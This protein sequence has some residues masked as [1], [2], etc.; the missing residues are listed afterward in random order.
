MSEY[1]SNVA[2]VIKNAPSQDPAA[3]ITG[4]PPN[5]GR[6]VLPQIST[7][8]GLIS[9]ISRA[10]RASDEALKHALENARFMRNDL[11]IMECVESR[12]RSVALLNWHLEPED[13]KSPLQKK[14]CEDLTSTILRIPRFTQFRDVL[15]HAIWF[16]RYAIQNRYQWRDV[17]GISRCLPTAW[18][19]VNGDKLVFRIDDGS[20]DPDQVGIRVGQTVKLVDPYGQERS[21]EL[22]DRG[23]AYFLEPWERKLLCLHRHMIEDGEF[24]S[25]ENADRINGVGIRSRIYWEWFQ[26]QE[27]LGF[28]MEYL[29]RSAFGIEIWYYPMGNDNA[30]EATR[31]AASERIG[32]GR[33]I[34][35]VGKPLGEDGAAYG[36]DRIE[37][38]LGGVEA[39]KDILDKY[40]GHRI[41]RYILGQTLTSEAD[42]TG[43]GSGL[44]E[45]HLGTYLDIIKYDATNLEETLTTDLVEIIKNWNHPE[46]SGVH[47]RFVIETESQDSEKKLQA[48]KSAYDMGCRL[49]ESDIMEAI[50]ASIPT[51]NDRVLQNQSA[52]QPPGMGSM[53]GQAGF[54]PGKIGD[55]PT[56]TQNENVRGEEDETEQYAR[57]PAKGQKD[58]F[59]SSGKRW[60]TIGSDEGGGT[61]VQINKKGQIVAGPEALT[62]KHVG[63]LGTKGGG[64][65]D[66]DD[67]EED[68]TEESNSPETPESSSVPEEHTA[69]EWSKALAHRDNL[70]ARNGRNHP[71]TQRAK[72]ILE[73]MAAHDSA[74][75]NWKEGDQHPSK[76]DVEALL[77]GRDS[78]ATPSTKAPTPSE[79]PRDSASTPS[80][81]PKTGD[82]SHGTPTERPATSSG[83]SSDPVTTPDRGSPT[84]TYQQ[85]LLKGDDPREA[86]KAATKAADPDYEFAR[87]SAIPNAGA[88]LKGS[89]RHK[90]NAWKSLQEMEESGDAE[91]MVNRDSLLKNEPADLTKNP[92]NN[93]LSTLAMHLALRKYPAKPGHGNER[94]RARITPETAKKDREQYVETY[95]KIKAKAEEFSSSEVDYKSAVSKLRDF[96]GAQILELRGQKDTTYAGKAGATDRYNNTAN[97]LVDMYNQLG[98]G[99]WESRKKNNIHY[100]INTFGDH[101]HQNYSGLEVKDLVE[102]TREH[103][104]DVLEGNSIDKSFGVAAKSK[105]KQ[106]SPSEMYVAHGSREGGP[107]LSI[108]TGNALDANKFMVERLGLKGV[109]YGNSVTDEERQHHARMAAEALADLTDILGLD[110]KT[111]SLNGNLGLAIG[112]RGHGN[113]LAHYES[114]SKV[115]NLTRKS[116]IGSLAHEWGHAF[117]HHIGRRATGYSKPF[118]S[119]E[120]VEK[121]PVLKDGKPYSD[122]TGYMVVDHI[123]SDPVM[124]AMSKLK[125]SWMTS[126]YRDRL[127]KVLKDHGIK[128]RDYWESP[129]EIFARSFERYL[130]NKLQSAGR[131][132]TYL[133]GIETKAYKNGGL[134]PT[135]EEVAHMTPHFDA[136]FEA[137]RLK[138]NIQPEKYSRAELVDRY[139]REIASQGR[140]PMADSF[141][142]VFSKLYQ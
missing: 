26:K 25:P 47:V 46:A 79:P 74:V 58:L 76:P 140:H 55:E 40:Y 70:L 120:Y 54:G 129:H 125:S 39:L 87:A 3:S 75:G 107:D 132:N 69:E 60:I 2:S 8:Q 19:P 88:D 96:I 49:K 83:L 16:G 23:M 95:R 138:H 119:H 17:G 14:L 127:P 142:A 63:S 61:H 67:D 4:A 82:D 20:H 78:P 31:K 86:A 81:P 139:M 5:L 48:F 80:D 68:E 66:Q 64:K 92:N 21:T 103:V 110:A 56:E 24:E 136:L 85:S 38:G 18:K 137:Y 12:Q 100:S 117:D 90:V 134:W 22:T 59:D 30:L 126:G 71:E 114:D 73:Q 7:I 34:I 99:S 33:N 91:R 116:G 53:F 123:H 6:F 109:Q 15:Q 113:A 133:A 10:Y 94:A 1:S 102:K 112:A 135:D 98:G 37:P 9:T 77:S 105:D 62:G 115:I 51:E 50:G 104:M 42:A 11:G 32:E 131:K 65:E 122:E 130:Q 28:L 141:D 43:L 97:S 72:Q 44:A 111:A 36:V 41:K 27:L 52:G 124:V 101:L 45:L 13:T 118:G 89:A 35:L 29:E 93:P 128:N 106:F 108:H 84:A 121:K 57:K